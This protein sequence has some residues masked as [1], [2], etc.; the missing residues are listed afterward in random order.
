MDKEYLLV[1]I[2]AKESFLLDFGVTGIRPVLQA[3]DEAQTWLRD[4]KKTASYAVIS[5]LNNGLCMT[6][7]IRVSLAE[8]SAS[9]DNVYFGSMESLTE[10]CGLKAGSGWSQTLNDEHNSFT[11]LPGG[12]VRLSAVPQ[13]GGGSAP[14]SVE[15]PAGFFASMHKHMGGK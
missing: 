14:V 1:P 10:H 5:M 7:N 6:V 9:Q 15:I 12:S 4:V 11:L 2:D 8:Y 3:M 13:T